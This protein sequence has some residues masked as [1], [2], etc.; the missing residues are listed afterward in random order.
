MKAMFS[1][2]VSPSGGFANTAEIV[3][4]KDRQL[5]ACIMILNYT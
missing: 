3:S 4:T 1:A 2:L 5:S